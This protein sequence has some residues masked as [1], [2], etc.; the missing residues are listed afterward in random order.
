MAG[1]VPYTQGLRSIAA[2]SAPSRLPP[3]GDSW[4]RSTCAPCASRTTIWWSRPQRR[5][6]VPARAS[7]EAPAGSAGGLLAVTGEDLPASEPPGGVRPVPYGLRL[8]DTRDW[9]I[10]TVDPDAQTFDVAGGLL[11]ARRWYAASGLNPIGVAAYDLAGNPRWR[12]F[13][14]ANVHV[15]APGGRRVYIDVGDHGKRRTHV[16]ELATG[17]SIRVVPYR[18]LSLLDR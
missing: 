14:G 10:R 6:A 18:R 8:V 5:R 15:W 3:T 16:V 9:T 12:R 1:V 11:L 7:P 17:R 2:A 13:S 4:P